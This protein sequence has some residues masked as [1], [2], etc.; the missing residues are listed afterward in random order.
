[1]TPVYPI[2]INRLR[3]HNSLHFTINRNPGSPPTISFQVMNGK[4][5]TR[6]EHCIAI[7]AGDDHVEVR[8]IQTILSLLP[9]PGAR[10]IDGGRV[11][12]SS[13]RRRGFIVDGLRV[14]RHWYE[15]RVVMEGEAGILADLDEVTF[16]VDRD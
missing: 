6:E 4:H 9:P 15:G 12:A 5:P 8:V 14:L 16:L 2:D 3:V 11:S 1:M 13:L 10:T 7:L